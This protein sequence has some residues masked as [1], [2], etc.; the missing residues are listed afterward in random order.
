MNEDDYGRDGNARRRPPGGTAARELAEVSFLPDRP[1]IARGRARSPRTKGTGAGPP[2]HW[3]GRPSTWPARSLRRSAQSRRSSAR[4]TRPPRAASPPKS[5]S[6]RRWRGFA[7]EKERRRERNAAT[8][9]DPQRKV[10]G[11]HLAQ[12]P[13]ASRQV[14]GRQRVRR[15][16]GARRRVVE[17]GIVR[18][19]QEARAA[20]GG[21]FHQTPGRVPSKGM[22][23]SAER[24]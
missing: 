17:R 1:R 18:V 11:L 7:R 15:R 19:T 4:S 14:Q 21:D 22:G 3:C 6:P 10:D 24:A 20:Q 23:S 16:A 13:A 12:R 9:G 8:H 2:A 5:R